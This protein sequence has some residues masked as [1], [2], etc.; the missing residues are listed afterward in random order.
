M[1]ISFVGGHQIFST[2]WGAERGKRELKGAVFFPSSH[3]VLVRPHSMQQFPVFLTKRQQSPTFYQ[4]LPASFLPTSMA[5]TLYPSRHCSLF[6]LSFSASLNL[7]AGLK[8]KFKFSFIGMTRDRLPQAYSQ[9]LAFHKATCPGPVTSGSACSAACMILRRGSHLCGSGHHY[10][11]QHYGHISV[12]AVTETAL[13]G[14]LTVTTTG[15][16]SQGF[17]RMDVKCAYVKYEIN[18]RKAFVRAHSH[19]WQK[20]MR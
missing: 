13:T 4:V 6:G 15:L 8:F 17:Q 18:Q 16:W 7:C 12:M 9:C 19:V 10:G 2:G 1:Q 11:Q 20:F 14:F 3:F 5:H